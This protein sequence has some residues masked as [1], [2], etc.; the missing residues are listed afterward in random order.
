[1][2]NDS[3]ILLLCHKNYYSKLPLKI[4]ILTQFL[5]FFGP[6]HFKNFCKILQKSRYRRLEKN[7]FAILT[8]ET[9]QQIYCDKVV[10]YDR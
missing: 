7:R 2:S 9:T 8:N 1:M 10:R 6:I 4:H 3:F 5:G